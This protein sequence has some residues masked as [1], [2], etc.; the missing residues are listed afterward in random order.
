MKADRVKISKQLFI[1][2]VLTA[3]LFSSCSTMVRIDSNVEDATI[4]IN[5]IKVGETPETVELSDFIGYTYDVQIEKK[6]YETYRGKLV[7]EVKVDTFVWGWFTGFWPWLWMY[8][9]APYQEFDLERK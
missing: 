6:G 8:G 5:G 2:F 3:V 9:P 1:G 7:K 4:R